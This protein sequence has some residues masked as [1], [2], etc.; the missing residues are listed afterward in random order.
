M[1]DLYVPIMNRPM[2]Q[3]KKE[4]LAQQLKRL[5]P[6]AVFL[7]FDRI[8]C[9]DAMLEEHLALYSENMSF[10]QSCGFTVYAWLAPTIGYGG[11]VT[12]FYGD[13][14]AAEE[15][16][17]ITFTNGDRVYAYCPYDADFVQAF[18]KTVL[19]VC[20]T[21]VKL[22]LLEDDFTLSGGKTGA[23]LACCCP[24]HM[25]RLNA[26]WGEEITDKATLRQKLLSGGENRYRDIWVQ[27]MGDTL[28]D[29]A[30]KI[31]QCVHA[32]DPEIRIGLCANASSYDIECVDLP[33]LARIIAGP[34]RP[35]IRMTGAPYWKNAKTLAPNI[36]AVRLQD[37]W[38]GSEIETVTEGDTCPRPRHRVAAGVLEN[39]DMILRASADTRGI[40]KYVLDYTS[41]A[42]YETG[43]IDRHV[44]HA[45]IY[46]EIE[47]RFWGKEPVGVNIFENRK[48][49]RR[50]DFARDGSL[51]DLGE[52]GYL[53]TVSQWL[54]CDNSL[55]MAYGAK[56]YAHVVF[57][58]NGR[59]VTKEMPKDGLVLDLPAARHLMA[60]GVDVGIEAIE[61]A[62]RPRVEYF[63][64]E[65]EYTDIGTERNG[66]FYQLTLRHGAQVQSSFLKMESKN[67]AV[68]GGDLAALPLFPACYRYENSAGQR[69]LVYACAMGTVWT[70]DDWHTGLFG[71]YCRQRQLIDGI[72]WVQRK[73]L[74]AVCPGNP[75]L[76]LLCKKDK[77]E[78]EM[79]VGVWNLSGDEVLSPV[80]TLDRIYQEIDCFGCSGRLEGDRVYL[81]EDILPYQRAFFT[82]K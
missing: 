7:V 23:A 64:P 27:V 33:E 63:H 73:P 56:G 15:F 76:Y 18:L 38:C 70:A 50:R 65:Q 19:A 45:P 57:G 71:N 82:V 53:P 60:Q 78:K 20:R 10:L 21:G 11:T 80:I 22:I 8:L 34:T 32:Y 68:P 14:S 25:E 51:Q 67:L 9:N 2:S 48:M 5:E 77:E 35:W 28:R 12:P 42:T 69:F 6:T 43:Y 4:R 39:Y 26:L 74:P 72:A 13:N 24:R 3:E 54:I 66:L 49:L 16:T 46:A 36:E 44:K 81:N 79:A 55:P 40:L 59:Y 37:Y 41:S 61:D 47:R 1:Y 30:Q 17:R 29:F 75:Y 31:E 52:R 58:E 62:T